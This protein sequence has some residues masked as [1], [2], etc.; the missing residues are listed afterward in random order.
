MKGTLRSLL[1]V[2]LAMMC[3]LPGAALLLTATHRE[4]EQALSCIL[5]TEIVGPALILGLASLVYFVRNA[6]TL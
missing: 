4:F 5:S 1:Y 3:I 6:R 2:L